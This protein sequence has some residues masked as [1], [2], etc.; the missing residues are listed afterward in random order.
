MV[1]SPPSRQG[2]SPAE[3]VLAG[4]SIYALVSLLSDPHHCSLVKFR[5]YTNTY[6]LLRIYALVSLLSH[7][8]LNQHSSPVQVLSMRYTE[9]IFL[10]S[11][12]LNRYP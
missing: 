5:E 9:S 11:I 6:K 2:R 3:L 1:S 4:S 12:V 7:P 8:P 10:V